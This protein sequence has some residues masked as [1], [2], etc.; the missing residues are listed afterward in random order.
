MINYERTQ[1]PPPC[2]AT[3]RKYDCEGVLIQ[4]KADFK[5]KCYLCEQKAPVSLNIEHFKPHKGDERLKLDWNNLFFVCAH[6]N[7]CKLAITQFDDILN[8]TNPA[9]RI[10]DRIQFDIKPFPKEYP[11]IRAITADE[12]TK[13]TV[14]LLEKIYNG[15]HTANKLI[16]SDNLRAALKTEIKLFGQKLDEYYEEDLQIQEKERI[17]N[18]IKRMLAASSAFTAFK[19]WIIKENKHLLAEFKQFLP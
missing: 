12:T 19:T 13:N 3:T 10:V 4:L 5:N 18:E 14:S 1:P 6:C 16:A 9:I 11:K 17:K 2:L 7:N 15:E 8:C